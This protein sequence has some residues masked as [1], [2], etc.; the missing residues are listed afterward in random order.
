MIGIRSRVVNTAERLVTGEQD[1]AE[2]G[3]SDTYSSVQLRRTTHLLD[4]VKGI[5]DLPLGANYVTI[6]V[7][8]LHQGIRD[9]EYLVFRQLLK[10]GD[11]FEE[12]FVLRP[13]GCGGCLQDYLPGKTKKW[14]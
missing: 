1:N 3:S 6:L 8:V 4:D 11:A 9:G 12:R 10:S 2:R 14:E 5:S 13:S 7:G